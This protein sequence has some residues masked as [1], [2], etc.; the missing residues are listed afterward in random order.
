MASFN[1]SGCAEIEVPI[2]S[3]SRLRAGID[4]LAAAY[5]RADHPELL[6][7]LP[8]LGHLLPP[9]VLERLREVR[10]EEKYAALWV[11]SGP[12]ADDPGATPAPT[13]TRHPGATCRYDIWLALLV[14]QLGDPI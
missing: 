11:R 7:L 2:S 12:I 5:C 3:V 14:A 1:T 10:Y 4:E 8:S 9:L 13:T 6:R